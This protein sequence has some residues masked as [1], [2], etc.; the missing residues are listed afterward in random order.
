MES[1]LAQSDSSNLT[2]KDFDRVL[3]FCEKFFDSVIFQDTEER[4]MKMF[5]LFSKMLALKKPKK[6]MKRAIDDEKVETTKKQKLNPI[7]IP[8]V[9][10]EIWL[11]VLNFMRSKNIFAN[12]ALVCKKFHRLTLDTRAVKNIKLNNIKCSEQFKNAMKVLK[13]SKNLD[14]VKIDNSPK[15][16]NNFITQAFKANPKLKSLIVNTASINKDWFKLTKSTK[17]VFGKNLET[18]KFVAITLEEIVNEILSQNNLKTLHLSQIC[19]TNT[20]INFL[21]MLPKNCKKLSKVNFSFIVCN[22][23]RRIQSSFDKFFEEAK[24]N[25]KSFKCHSVFNYDNSQN[26][27]WEEILKNLSLCQNLEVLEIFGA[28]FISNSTLTMIS[29]LPNLK[30]LTL[31]KLENS[32]TEFGAFFQKTNLEKLE[33]LHFEGWYYIS[34][35]A[36]QSLSNRKPPNLKE[37]WI[38]T[39][40][41]LKLQESTLNNLKNCPKLKKIGLKWS[42]LDG[43]STYQLH[44]FNKDIA[45]F[46]YHKDKWI[47]FEDLALEYTFHRT[48]SSID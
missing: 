18:L 37:I 31:K 46:L 16:C 17:K 40:Q 26:Q 35:E 24:E 6:S 47:R 3:D 9:P 48:I 1:L 39:G 30:R 4:T 25:L 32:R 13:R 34:N 10:D 44:E 22:D 15:Y 8:H 21:N 12:F 29:K 28:T 20:E 33:Y 19:D 45:I 11:K 5:D 41:N 7:K 14:K 2:D 36:L 43:I 27:R 38:L 42:N 23:V